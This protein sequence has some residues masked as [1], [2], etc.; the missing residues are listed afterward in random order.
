MSPETLPL[1][2]VWHR[3]HFESLS[4]LGVWCGRTQGK[5]TGSL[6]AVDT[7]AVLH[8]IHTPSVTDN[9]VLYTPGHSLLVLQSET[10]A[11][12]LSTDIKTQ[13]ATDGFWGG[14]LTSVQDSDDNFSRDFFL[15]ANE[16]LCYQRPED[17][18]A[19]VCVLYGIP[20]LIGQ[21]RPYH[22]PIIGRAFTLMWDISCAHVR[23]VRLPNHLMHSAWGQRPFPPYHFDRL[24]LGLWISLD[25]CLRPSRGT[26]G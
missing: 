23:H 12:S 19:R 6:F 21:L 11:T 22:I 26:N 7:G 15:D 4:D 14:V 16:I 24:R 3:P 5:D 25:P 20:V 18:R 8:C 1:R 2:H 17:S 13:V 10:L 9:E